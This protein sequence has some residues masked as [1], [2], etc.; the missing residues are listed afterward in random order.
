MDISF[1][2]TTPAF[3]A[4]YKTCTRRDWT[5]RTIL[6]V[7]HAS[8][9]T[10]LDIGRRQHG[11]PIADIELTGPVRRSRLLPAE[12]WAAEGFGWLEEAGIRLNGWTPREMWDDFASRP[13]EDAPVAV[14]RFRI[15][16]LTPYGSELLAAIVDQGHPFR[17]LPA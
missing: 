16:R 14:V 17:R 4:G 9:L 11:Q 8:H 15:K 1:A 2:W 5:D 6:A 10:A 3:L 13:A 12:D 7:N